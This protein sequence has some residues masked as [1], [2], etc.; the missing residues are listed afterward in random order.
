MGATM[1]V[2]GL[3]HQAY[4]DDPDSFVSEHGESPSIDVTWL[5]DSSE[6]FSHVVEKL[7]EPELSAIDA[8]LL[9]DSVCHMQDERAEDLASWLSHWGFRDRRIEGVH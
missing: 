2:V 3:D 8:L 5:R 1:H 4:R 6:A 9:A 7:H